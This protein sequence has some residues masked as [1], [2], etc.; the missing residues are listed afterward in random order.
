MKELS[1]EREK[2]EKRVK[3][4]KREKHK[5]TEIKNERVREKY[6]QRDSYL[7][8]KTAKDTETK[9]MLSLVNICIVIRFIKVDNTSWSSLKEE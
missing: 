6:I 2:R 5:D 4:R 1:N 8:K 3:G 7:H 9:N